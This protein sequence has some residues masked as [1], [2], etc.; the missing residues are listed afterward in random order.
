MKATPPAPSPSSDLRRSR[1]LAI[2]RVIKGELVSPRAPLKICDISAGGF[3]METS[4]PVRT[5]EVL[6]FRFSA[7]D[8]SSIL[9]RATVAHSRQI[10]SPIGPVV[11]L[12]GLEFAAKFTT[13]S[14]QAIKGLLEEVRLVLSFPKSVSA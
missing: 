12:S 13:R 9:V 8:G 10:S 2:D 4:F 7:R 3:A 5:G 1:R 14:Q 11:Y 6:S